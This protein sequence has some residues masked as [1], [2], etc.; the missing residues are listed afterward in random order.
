MSTYSWQETTIA[1]DDSH[2][3]I[4]GMPFYSHR[5]KH[6]LKYH[7]P[8]LAP[9]KDKTGAYHI[10][11]DGKPSYSNRYLQ[12]F[13]YYE[14]IAAV[15]SSNG[16]M[17]IHLDG[18][19][20]YAQHFAWC[21][22]FQ[23]G[24]CTVRDFNN[25]YYHILTDGKPCYT[26]R[27]AYAGD[28]KD[29]FAVVHTPDGK[30]THIDKRGCYLHHKWFDDLDVYHKAYARAKTSEGWYHVDKQ[31]MPIYQER[32]AAI[33]PFYNNVARVESFEGATLV[34]NTQGKAISTLKHPPNPASQLSN[35]MV[36]FWKTE[37]IATAVQLG[38]FDVLPATSEDIANRLNLPLPHLQRLIRS[39]WELKLISLEKAKWHLSASG[40]LLCHPSYL[41]S[42]A[43]LWSD[44]NNN[45]WKKLPEYIRKGYSQHH[46]S[47][48]QLCTNPEKKYHYL[49]AL[50]GYA[51]QDFNQLASLVDW[52][53]HVSLIGVGYSAKVVLE[54]L[55]KQFP[56]LRLHFNSL[57]EDLTSDNNKRLNYQYFNI[58]KAWP[59]QG[60]AI[61]LPKVLHY[62]PEQNTLEIL[63]Y[64]GNALLPDGKIYILEM[65][66]SND[67][68]CGGLLDLNMLIET[69]GMLRTHSQWESI[70]M[71]AN[72]KISAS[73]PISDYM[74][75]LVL[76]YNHCK[77]S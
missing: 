3:L 71:A 25:N 47:F 18:S 33:E 61:L 32:F 51:Q 59:I 68:A 63:N 19:A 50:A 60:D 55:N 54:D 22:N 53:K 57:Q 8:G 62:W 44:V 39:L 58:Q 34:I 70:I 37:V 17:H 26:E 21:G 5:F 36:G 48:K 38:I 2:H 6:V 28:F 49:T 40:Q 76:E 24:L 64:A 56:H 43:I 69:G 42:A 20:C 67:Q 23:E 29:G 10:D 9:V 65:L 15:E 73:K 7:A 12:T 14:S 45:A 16:W 13:G 35:D 75:L 52:N 77:V 11:I 27:Y 4:K 30:C 1:P 72:L 66:L 46:A 41:A 31:G 74:T